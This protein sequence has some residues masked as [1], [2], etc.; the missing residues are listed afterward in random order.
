MRPLGLAAALCATSAAAFFV[1]C[2]ESDSGSGGRAVPHDAAPIEDSAGGGSDAAADSSRGPCE[3]NDTTCTP[4]QLP[5]D[6]TDFCPVESPVDA[7]LALSAVWGSGAADVW[8][9]GAGGTIVHWEGS[10]WS[11]VPSGTTYTLNAI[12]GSGVDDFWILSAPEVVLRPDGGAFERVPP[13]TTGSYVNGT[14]LLRSVWVSPGGERI[15]VGGDAVRA[16]GTIDDAQVWS[17]ARGETTWTARSRIERF[18]VHGLWASSADEVWIVGQPLQGPGTALRGVMDSDAGLIA[19]EP[20][21][22]Q[23]SNALEAVW[24]SGKDDVWTVGAGGTIRHLSGGSSRWE[25][26]PSPTSEDLHAVWG[27]AANDVW[28]AGDGGTL[29]H[30]NGSQLR[31]LVAS[32]PV[33][34]TPHLYGIW[35]S[36]PNDVWAVGERGTILYASVI[37]SGPQGGEP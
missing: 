7:R 15:L 22:V 35:G 1:S 19:F 37:R 14:R 30:W 21:D 9:V 23:A 13:V 20:T 24:G 5:C 33:G 4:V 3:P 18:N 32:F 2:A 16:D 26:V 25:I 29:L 8:A 17:A 36:G 34:R 27:S 10:K 6:V 12:G 31:R 28:I 11:V